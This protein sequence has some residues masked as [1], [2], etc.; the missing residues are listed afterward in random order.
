MRLKYANRLTTFHFDFYSIHNYSFDDF[1]F[2][3]FNVIINFLTR[4]FSFKRI[5]I[6]I[7]IINFIND[8]DMIIIKINKQHHSSNHFIYRS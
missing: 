4:N 7:I 6:N 2:M 3:N 5:K 8:R 1:I